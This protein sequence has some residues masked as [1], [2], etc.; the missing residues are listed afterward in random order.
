MG[1]L[2]TDLSSV[3]IV[4]LDVAKHV[5]QVHC[6]DSAGRVIVARALR[7]G[8]VLG[9]FAALP[10]CRV[11]L[12]ACGS[13]HHWGRALQA[14][15]HDV[16]MMPAA[17]VKPYV[18]RQKNDAADAAAIAEALTRPSMRFV[19]VRSVAN[20]AALMAHRVR[21]LLVAQRTQLLNSLRGHLAEVGLIATQGADHARAGGAD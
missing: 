5:F 18:K 15:G 16:K 7:R 11:G 4:G 19:A 13:A 2:S 6:Q 1:E 3:T 17:Y 12:E 21:E 9:F 14:L 8:Q 20:R 10:P